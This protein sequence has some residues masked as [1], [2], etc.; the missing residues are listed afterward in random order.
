M[1]RL[2]DMTAAERS[3]NFHIPLATDGREIC[4]HFLSKGY[5]ISYCTHSHAPMREQNRET[6]IHYIRIGREVIN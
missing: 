4:L 5:C 2:G 1:E 3:E 6:V